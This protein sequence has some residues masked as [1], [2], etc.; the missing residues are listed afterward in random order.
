MYIIVTTLTDSCVVHL[1]LRYCPV[2]A[3]TGRRFWARNNVMHHIVIYP[4]KLAGA[5]VKAARDAAKRAAA[6]VAA[7]KA[8][9]AR[10]AA[11]QAAAEAAAAAERELRALR[12]RV[13]EAEMS[14]EELANRCALG[15]K[16]SF[17]TICLA[18][19]CPVGGGR[20]EHA[21]ACKQ[22]RAEFDGVVTTPAARILLSNA[23]RR[24][25][26]YIP[27]ACTVQ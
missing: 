11:E 19:P 18:S 27:E 23:R 7:F 10:D 26:L 3:C 21:S 20:E 5:Q 24:P 8:V 22:V 12:G 6:E 15:L 25:E 9:A 16:A 17:P 14:N 13:A 2:I 4:I 1:Y